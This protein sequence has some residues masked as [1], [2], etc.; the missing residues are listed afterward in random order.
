M[1]IIFIYNTEHQNL[2]TELPFAK[3]SRT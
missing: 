1:H 3:Y 2:K